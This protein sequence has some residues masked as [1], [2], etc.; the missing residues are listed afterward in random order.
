MHNALTPPWLADDAQLELTFKKGTTPLSHRRWPGEPVPLVKVERL[1]RLANDIASRSQPLAW[2][3][4][5][6]LLS[7]NRRLRRRCAAWARPER[8]CPPAR[9]RC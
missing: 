2:E 8:Q 5:N 4:D 1:Q 9:W 3:A 6:V 7:G